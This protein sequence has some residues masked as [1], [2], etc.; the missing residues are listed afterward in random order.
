MVK[1]AVVGIGR[2]GMR[3]AKMIELNDSTDIVAIIDNDQ[4]KLQSLDG[5]DVPKFSSLESFLAADIDCDVVSICTPNYL[6][7][8]QSIVALHHDLHVVVEK[9]FA[10]YRKEAEE[11]IELSKKKG[12]SVFC[13]MQNRYSPPSKWL[14]GLMNSNVLG[15][16]YLVNINC[17]WNRDHAYYKHGDANHW[18]GK[19]MEDGGTLFTQ[20]SHFVDMMYWL[21]G[22]IKNISA[23]FYDFNHQEVT[24]FEDSGLVQFD[25]VNGGHGTFNYSTAVYE[26]NLES[27]IT[28]IAEKGSVK[29]GGQYMNTVEYCNIKDYVMPE[30]EETLPP[31]DYGNYQ[32]SAANHRF[33][34][35]NVVDSI[36]NEN[37]IATNSLEGLKVVEII[38]NIYTFK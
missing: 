26:K 13:V 32:G 7:A 37:Q 14:K 1:I 33:V 9:P 29:V 11:V 21:F 34:Y 17:Y 36:K 25:F 38:E 8:K 4:N 20:F 12:K 18:K 16:I 23:R 15:D 3:H 6:H 28:I 31:N 5:F 10:L 27:S 2:I 22:D 35:Q 24:E 19:N 30:L